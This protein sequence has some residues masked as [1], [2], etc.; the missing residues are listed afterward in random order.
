MCVA[1]VIYLRC[2]L[3]LD[4]LR[5]GENKIYN[6]VL[7]LIIKTQTFLNFFYYIFRSGDVE[8]GVLLNRGLYVV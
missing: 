1:A 3:P 8:L 7:G 2:L 6:Y 4:F 5:F